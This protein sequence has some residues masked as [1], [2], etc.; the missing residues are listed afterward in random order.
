MVKKK[1][2]RDKKRISLCM[3]V[4]DEEKFLPQ[5]LDSVK[6]HVDEIVVVDTGSTDRTVEIAKSYGAKV[7]HHPWENNFS[8]HRNQSISYATGDWILIMDA[9]EELDAET[10]PMLRKGVEEALTPVFLFNVKSFLSNK[11][12]HT[13]GT[14][15]RLFRSGLGIHYQGYVHNQLIFKDKKAT[16]YPVAIWH[17]G[18]DLSPEQLK[19]KRE[20]S[21]ALLNKQ[22]KDFPDDLPTRHHLAMTWLSSKEYE[23]AYQ[24]AKLTLDMMKAQGKID[25]NFSWTYF[26]AVM[27]LINLGRIDEAETL[28]NE[29]LRFFDKSIDIHHCIVQIGF[30]K[31][32][33][34]KILKHGREFFRLREELCENFSQFK[35]FQFETAHKD[36]IVYRAMGY[37]HIYLGHHDEGVDFLTKAAKSAPACDADTLRQEIGLNL[38]LLKEWEKATWFLDELPRE[39]RQYKHGLMELGANYERL[40]RLDEAVALYNQIEST[41]EENAGIPFKR[42]SLLLKLNRYNEAAAAFEKA[43]KRSPDYVDAW[44]NWGLALEDGGAKEIAE[45]KYRAALAIDPDS[46]KGNLNL[47]LFYFKQGDYARAREYL[48]KSAADFAENV[49]LCLALSRAYLETGEIEAMVGTCEKALRC[50][51]LPSDF[52]IESISQLAELFLGIAEKLL[53]EDRLKAFDLAL[54]I[55]LLLGPERGDALTGLAQ[56]AFGMGEY[57]RAA[58]ILEE[59]L[60]IDPKNPE[61]LNLVQMMTERLSG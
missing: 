38:V 6:D 37:A 29:A 48:E 50:L 57:E 25:T 43:A 40:G 58:K 59:A 19:A 27:S 45:E 23:K 17:Y 15:A 13:E 3:I 21:L 32:D 36:W 33:Y 16:H 39:E 60:A 42:G 1:Q 26:I 14:S 41:F 46:P 47:G 52:L 53:K 30:V 54:E 35:S 9:D 31:K 12:Y 7:Y 24:D 51:D 28:A 34:N 5:C 20:R 56:S 49:Y 2:K 18:Y 55:A 11:N 10:A 4:K 8:K 22:I 61:N 44:I